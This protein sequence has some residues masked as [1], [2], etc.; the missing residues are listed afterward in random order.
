M[1]IQ[2][3]YVQYQ[4]VKVK[5]FEDTEEALSFI[6][7]LKNHLFLPGGVVLMVIA[8]EWARTKMG[9]QSQYTWR[10]LMDGVRSQRIDDRLDE[11]LA[12]DAAQ[13]CLHCDTW[14]GGKCRGASG[15]LQSG[16]PGHSHCRS[17]L[18]DSGLLTRR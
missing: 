14:C 1:T 5:R 9:E 18:I 17:R 11:W 16:K 8:D 2:V 7:A 10:Y 3:V 12:H 6:D 15:C 4:V 13:P